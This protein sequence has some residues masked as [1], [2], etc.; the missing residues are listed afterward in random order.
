[1]LERAMREWARTDPAAAANVRGADRR[2]LRVVTKAYSDYG[3]SP[4]DA[5]LRAELDLCGRHQAPAPGRHRRTGT[6]RDG[7]GT[8][9]GA[10]VGRPARS[11]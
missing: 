8:I 4:A 3:L 2:L 10:H 7:T 9:P 5:K 1:M 6:K 11:S